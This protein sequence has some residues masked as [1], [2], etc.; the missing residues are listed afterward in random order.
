MEPAEKQRNYVLA[1]ELLAEQNFAAAIIAGVV[2]MIIAAGIYGVAKSVS[3][4]LYYS[5]L[6]A[7]LGVA[8]GFAMQYV[9]RGIATKFTVAAAACAALGCLLSNLFAVAMR[10]ARAL[11]VSPFDVI[12]NTPVSELYEWLFRGLHFA[13]VMFWIIG[14]GGAAYFARRPLTREESLA[15]HTYKMQL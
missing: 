15:V 2:A 12:R 6:A 1:E 14:I 7:G 3:E 4:S 8:I 13:D 5:I 10:I 9:G 11:V